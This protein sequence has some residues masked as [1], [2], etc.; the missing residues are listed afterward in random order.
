[1]R[2]SLKNMPLANV[3]CI[4]WGKAYG[5]E[6]V[7]KLY[8]MVSRNMKKHVLHFYCFTDDGHNLHK[9][10]IVK[11]LPKINCAQ[12]DIK[13]V[14]QKE[15][16]LCDDNLGGLNGQRVLFFDLDVVITGSLD[17]FVSFPKKDE[18]IIINDWNTRGNAIGQA[19]CY[20]WKV[21]TLG[22]IK[23]YFEDNVKEV[24]KKFHTASQAYLSSKVIEKWGELK[25]WPEGWCRSFK[26]H[27]LPHWYL[28]PFFAPQLPKGTKV[29]AFHGHPKIEEAI[30]GVWS[31]DGVPL[32]K[33][34][35]K[36]I[37]P[38][39]WLKEYWKE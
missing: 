27:A 3:I 6:D 17:E 2:N 11:P 33:R 38:S 12:E 39:P 34:L 22:F 10:I 15:V 25:F 8:G 26:F 37:C 20:S 21:G 29:L 36:T 19:T 31:I 16:G 13:Y 1:M 14:Y 7:N 28:R 5:A 30:K 9:G 4:K 24:L 18:F 32:F 35:Y 23:K